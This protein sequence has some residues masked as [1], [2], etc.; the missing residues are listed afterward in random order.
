[1]G[2][3]AHG[4]GHEEGGLRKRKG[5]IRLQGSPMDFNKHLPTKPESAY[6]I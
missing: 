1:M 6:I 3:P 4:K 5:G 2:N